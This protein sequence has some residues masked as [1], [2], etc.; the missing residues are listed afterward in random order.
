MTP[1]QLYL[2]FRIT[3]IHPLILLRQKADWKVLAVKWWFIYRFVEVRYF[4]RGVRNLWREIKST[5]KGNY[6]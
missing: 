4:A 5:R 2:L 1:R 3:F 6:Q